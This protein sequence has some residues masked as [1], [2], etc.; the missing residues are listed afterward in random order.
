MTAEEYIRESEGITDKDLEKYAG[1]SVAVTGRVKQF[2][3]QPNGT[4][5]PARYTC[6][7]GKRT[8]HSLFFGTETN[9]EN[10]EMIKPDKIVTM[11]GMYE[12]KPGK[13]RCRSL[14]AL[15]PKRIKK[16]N[17][18]LFNKQIISKISMISGIYEHCHNGVKLSSPR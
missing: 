15:F 7:C 13:S 17:L 3:F 5:A 6:R 18:Y 1:K 9:V 11:Q 14:P 8:R 16:G 12:L 10:R 2:S 4:A